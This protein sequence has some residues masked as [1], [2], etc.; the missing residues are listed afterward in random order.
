MILSCQLLLNHCTELASSEEKKKK[1]VQSFP[2]LSQVIQQSDTKEGKLYRK[3]TLSFQFVMCSIGSGQGVEE[4]CLI[5][6]QKDLKLPDFP[7][8]LLKCKN[9]PVPKLLQGFVTIAVCA[10]LIYHG[11]FFFLCFIASCDQQ[12]QARMGKKEDFKTI[13]RT[14]KIYKTVFLAE[15]LKNSQD[16]THRIVQAFKGLLFKFVFQFYVV[17]SSVPQQ[18]DMAFPRDN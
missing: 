18:W 15:A 16:Y 14:L 9:A 4:L 12:D 5:L 11:V 10:S 13:G 1:Q 7:G 8:L 6:I 3:R 17:C 2:I